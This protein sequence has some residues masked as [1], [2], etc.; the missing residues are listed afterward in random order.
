[1]VGWV[2]FNNSLRYEEQTIKTMAKTLQHRGPDAEGYW[3]DRHVALGH[4][5]LI[6]VDPEGGRQPMRLATNQGEYILVYNGELYNTEDLRQSLLARGHSFAGWSDTEVLLRAYSEWGENCLPR[7]NGIFAFAVWDV[8]N[9]KLFMARDRIGVKPLF[10]SQKGSS[11]LFASEIKAILAHPGVTAKV[12]REGLA[13]IIALGPA[14]TPGHG[15]FAGISE[16]KPGYCMMV[17]R[18]GTRTKPYWSLISHDHED[19]LARTTVKVRELVYDAVKR[20]LVSDVPLCTLLS[21]G[22]DSSAITAIAAE[23]YKNENNERVQT[24]SIDYADNEQYFRASE[25][26]PDTD[27]PWIKIVSDYL[28]TRHASYLADTPE[29]VQTLYPAVIARDL[30]GMTDVDSSLWL[31]SQ[32]IKKQATVGISG[33]CTDEVFGGYPWFRQTGDYKLF[34]WSRHLQTR[35]KFYSAELLEWIKPGEYVAQR[36][37]EALEEVP[38]WADDQPTDARMREMFYLNL[39]RWMP[40][41]LDRK[42]RM[43][44]AA[45]L[46][47]RVPFCDHRLVEYVW[48]VPW[49]M[50]NYRSREKGLLRLALPGLLPEDVLWRKKSPYPKTHNPSYIEAIRNLALA[51]LADPSSPLLPFINRQAVRE[52]ALTVRSD[53][54]MPWF[55]QLMNAP[56]LLAFLLQTDFWLRYYHIEI[57]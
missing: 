39:T 20:Q 14:R 2:D 3:L 26:Q 34:P 43:S 50:K 33:E 53:T 23:V 32:W 19:S 29:L 28:D 41:L 24:F 16:V 1:M 21:G 57:R 56:Q 12:D 35:M 22:L 27:A 47:L 11:F 10:Y 13:E 42:D 30:P 45:G 7:L 18:S 54:D 51:M 44:M 55:G 31:F 25:L 38:R 52:L 5:R 4:C 8:Q 40:V 48:N 49:E 17:D 9:E 46:E 37:Q 6:V 36:Y 15:V